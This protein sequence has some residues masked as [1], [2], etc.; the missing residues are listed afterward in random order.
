[1]TTWLHFIGKTYYKN[2]SRFERE[3]A[4]YGITRRVALATLRKMEWGDR[5]L[6]AQRDGAST[7]VFGQFTIE[8]LSGLSAA[9]GAAVREALG[10]RLD[11]TPFDTPQRVERGCGTYTVT[12]VFS[13]RETS[14]AQLVAAVEKAED[15]GKLMVG[16]R[17][18]PLF[19]DANGVAVLPVERV[20]LKS[21]PHAQGFRPFAYDEWR[22][23]VVSAIHARPGKPVALRG[24]F[25]GQTDHERAVDAGL[26]EL[27]DDYRRGSRWEQGGLEI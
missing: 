1:M 22:S 2:T 18:A 17:Y 3:A 23:E 20:R 13:V 7:I 5:V 27:V 19:A 21:V 14:L 12:G 9:A 24:H 16:G 11:Y 10:D 6:L 25:Y 15:P 8:K 26:A 4:R